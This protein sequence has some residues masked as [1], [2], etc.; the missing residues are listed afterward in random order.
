VN[1]LAIVQARVSSTRLPGKVLADVG[2]EPML[3]LELARLRRA[4]QL[5]DIV[6]ATSRRPDDDPLAELAA[7]LGVRVHRGALEDVLG[8][9]AGA[10]SGHD[11][12]VVRLTGDCPLI[13]PA[14][15]DAVVERLAGA[16]EAVYASNVEP[17][18]TFPHG[19]DVEALRAATLAQLDREVTDPELRE[20]VTL[21]ARRDP[22]RYPRVSVESNED[23]SALRWTVDL[24][25]DLEF[26]R[27]LAERLGPNRHTA[28]WRDVLAA[29]RREPPLDEIG[30]HRRA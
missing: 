26:V 24:P 12:I 16:P 15:V 10:A 7:G 23:L 20:H 9:F 27:A 5:G 11:G 29:A 2:G 1:A 13:D 25:S 3:A 30:G 4:R 18:R 6:V 19:L 14:V 28:G 21:A 22:R 8:R 17:R